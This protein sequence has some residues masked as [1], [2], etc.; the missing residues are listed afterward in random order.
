MKPTTE[1]NRL[2][3][4]AHTIRERFS[5]APSKSGWVKGIRPTCQ[6]NFS[7]RKF[8]NLDSLLLSFFH[9]NIIPPHTVSFFSLQHHL[10]KDAAVLKHLS[11]GFAKSTPKEGSPTYLVGEIQ[12]L[13]IHSVS[14]HDCFSRE[15]ACS[16]FI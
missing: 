12:G 13:F 4:D 14:L 2:G 5:A 3:P 7:L 16:F 15:P 1:A 11:L 8:K 6:P 9:I 10:S